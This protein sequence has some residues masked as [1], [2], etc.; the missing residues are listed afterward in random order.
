MLQQLFLL[1]L[2]RQAFS[3]C[4]SVQFIDKVDCTVNTCRLSITRRTL[5]TIRRTDYIFYVLMTSYVA[6]T[7]RHN[8]S[9]GRR[10]RSTPSP[11]SRH[12]NSDCS[13]HSTTSLATVTP[14]HSHSLYHRH[15][16]LYW[17]C[18]LTR[19]KTL[20]NRSR[21]V[22]RWHELALCPPCTT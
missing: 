6:D 1:V 22:E 16:I 20:I 2:L 15:E 7:I 14:A 10:C 9:N 8:S 12:D 5:S 11:F 4:S 21:F 13:I 17:I 18:L 19:L 3:F